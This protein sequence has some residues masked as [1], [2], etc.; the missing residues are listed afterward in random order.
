MNDNYDTDKIIQQLN[1][2]NKNLKQS[3][4]KK[5]N[6][7][8]ELN[9]QKDAAEKR[10]Q[11]AQTKIN[12]LNQQKD[13]AEK[14]VQEA[15][16]FQQGQYQ[17][18]IIELF[19]KPQEELQQHI[20]QES[21]KAS[22]LTM[23]VAIVSI[24]VSL[25]LTIFSSWQSSQPIN[26]LQAEITLLSQKLDERRKLQ[27]EEQKIKEILHIRLKTYFK[28]NNE[29]KNINEIKPILWSYLSNDRKYVA[30]YE[31]FRQAFEEYGIPSNIIPNLHQ[32]SKFEQKHLE[33]S[34]KW[35][36]TLKNKNNTDTI[37]KDSSV[38]RLQTFMGS[39]YGT[40][41]FAGSSLTYKQLQQIIEERK[42]I[43]EE[44]LKLNGVNVR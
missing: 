36:E 39:D 42:K 26:N 21:N 29:L 28:D 17:G 27:K 35:I 2:L 13:A 7:I 10:V 8:N 44:R 18:L 12:E 40:W 22:Q 4:E 11:E 20:Q 43:I 41:Q 6:K 5:Q 30:K 14:Q 23:I 32:F 33:A 24:L 37:P 9:Q 15:I 34:K 3:L 25:G 1:E 19:K 38:R 31:L 16:E